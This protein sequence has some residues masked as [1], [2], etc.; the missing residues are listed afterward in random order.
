MLT[1]SVNAEKEILSSRSLYLSH[2]TK[3]KLQA[4]LNNLVRDT[5]ETAY[6]R[7]PHKFFNEIIAFCRFVDWESRGVGNS[8]WKATQL[9]FLLC[10]FHRHTT[11]I[12]STMF[13]KINWTRWLFIKTVNDM[14]AAQASCHNSFGFFSVSS[15]PMTLNSRFVNNLQCNA[16]KSRNLTNE[17]K[18]EACENVV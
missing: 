9:Q 12:H 3:L 7:L 1:M 4:S 15:S 8:P 14:Y 17:I 16:R 11:S 5:K 13:G 10:S 6:N 18:T 2:P